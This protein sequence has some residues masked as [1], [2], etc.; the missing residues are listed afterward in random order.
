MIATQ[1]VK[2]NNNKELPETV[3]GKYYL[4]YSF[5]LNI[6]G[7]GIPAI[8]IKLDSI[9]KLTNFVKEI[10]KNSTILLKGTDDFVINDDYYINK[11]V[12]SW[13]YGMSND[14]GS[15]DGSS[16]TGSDDIIKYFSDNI[17]VSEND[18]VLL[19][20]YINK[21]SL[22]INT[23]YFDIVNSA[24]NLINHYIKQNI[25]SNFVFTEDELKNF[26]ATFCNVILSMS[27]VIDN[28]TTNNVIYKKVLE[29]FANSCTDSVLLTMQI[30]LN[31]NIQNTTQ[32]VSSCNCNIINSTDNNICISSCSDYYI[33]A[34]NEYLK[35]MLG[36]I[37]FYRDWFYT[38]INID[39]VEFIN[40]DL[41]S[42]LKI[43][44][45]EL[46]ESGINLDTSEKQKIGLGCPSLSAA[47]DDC[48]RSIIK[49][50]I[51]LL[52]YIENDDIDSNINKIKVYGSAFAELLTKL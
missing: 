34:M 35:L 3:Q 33:N 49:N 43:L 11:S 4:Y 13:L 48:N 32:N 29:Y 10:S 15:S 40:T 45:N 30:M 22:N 42:R 46:L 25:Y 23:D 14:N 27:T 1:F 47:S 17:Y 50:Y 2:F 31:N 18:I 39:D 20:N 44:L 6:K 38:N 9:N 36:D 28:N 37:E 52:D 5:G 41:I 24:E 12:Y 21:S 7:D 19:P 26:S 51:K 16:D 8:Y